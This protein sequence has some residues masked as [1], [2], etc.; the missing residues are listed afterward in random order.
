MRIIVNGQQAF[1]KAALEAIL[2]AGKDEVV[3][4]YT[5]P[6]KEGRPPDPL[7]QAALERGIPLY[8]PASYKDAAVVDEMKALKPDLMV[9]AY[10]IIFVPENVRSVPTHGS[11]CFHPSLLPR[12]RGPSSINWPMAWGATKTGLTWFYP[13]DGLDE[14][15]ILLQREVEI[16]PDETLGQV[17][18]DKIF[19]L[20]VKTT[21]EA[22]DL[23]RSGKAP[24]VKQDESQAT[25]ESWF[26]K[27]HAKIDWEKPVADVYNV[28]RAANPQPG[29]WTTLNGTEVQV[30]D[31]RRREGA[32]EPGTVVDIGPEGVQVQA[33]GGR[34][35]LQRVRPKG[36]DKVAAADWVK[37]QGIAVGTKLGT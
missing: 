33:Q 3:A 10:M 19:P 8:Q 31:A 9:M 7:K 36:G 20:G 35:L 14:G 28:I 6:D 30:F 4:V 2:D 24:R 27:E 5:A 18:F 16:G 34:I 22:I 29:A 32:G 23:I 11:I 25:Y 1:G 15:D 12:H 17:Y 21:L 13:D 37:A 26:K